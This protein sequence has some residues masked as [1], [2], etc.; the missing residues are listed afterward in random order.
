MTSKTKHIG[1]LILCL[2]VGWMAVAP[3][4]A[5]DGMAISKDGTPVSYSV[6]GKGETT[7]V[8]VHGWSWGERGR[9]CNFAD[10]LALDVS[11]RNGFYNSR[12]I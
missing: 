1:F 9:S 7:L 6:S 2:T 3:L 10:A 12:F 8:F 4:R 11:Y 5:A